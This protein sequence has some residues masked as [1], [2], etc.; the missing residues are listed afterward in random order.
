[1]NCSTFQKEIINRNEKSIED[2]EKELHKIKKKF[3]EKN[4]ENTKSELK[5]QGD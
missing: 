3:Q 4:E 2:L 1:M 5:Y